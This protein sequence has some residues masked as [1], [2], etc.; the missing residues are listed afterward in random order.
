MQMEVIPFYKAAE[1]MSGRHMG[2]CA[3]YGVRYIRIRDVLPYSML[4][5]EAIVSPAG[6][7]NRLSDGDILIPRSG[8]N[9]SPYLYREETGPAAFA[10]FFYRIRASSPFTPQF[11]YFQ[12]RSSRFGKYWSMGLQGRNVTLSW[13]K[14]YPC[15]TS[16]G[17]G[18]QP[19][20]LAELSI[21]TQLELL[22]LLEDRWKASLRI[23]SIEGADRTLGDLC[24]NISGVCP[25]HKGDTPVI[26]PHGICGYTQSP[27]SQVPMV[28]VHKTAPIKVIYIPKGSVGSKKLFCLRPFK[29]EDYRDIYRILCASE[30]EKI[31]TP[32]TTQHLS[33]K[34]LLKIPCR[35]PPANGSLSCMEKEIQSAKKLLAL[36]Q[37]RLQQLIDIAFPDEL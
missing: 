31:L 18:I 19:L 1:V 37:K 34:P 25:E 29:G 20:W 14:E 7:W 30:L 17:I 2:S 13:I 5:K 9:P 24:E 23:Y 22:S 27:G 28:G 26:G 6:E 32:G 4:K 16:P 11:I 12:I 10:S 3:Y 33:L 21:R 15:L 8:S 36:C 35:V